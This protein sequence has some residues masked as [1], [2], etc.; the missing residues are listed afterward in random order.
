MWTRT[1]VR[2]N[3]SARLSLVTSMQR[4]WCMTIVNPGG[5]GPAV[6]ADGRDAECPPWYLRRP[7]IVH[8]VAQETRPS[9]PSAYAETAQS[10]SITQLVFVLVRRGVGDLV[11]WPV[12]G[13]GGRVV[14]WWGLG[15]WPHIQRP[16][17]PTTPRPYITPARNGGGGRRWRPGHRRNDRGRWRAGGRGMRPSRGCPLWRGAGRPRR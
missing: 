17:H 9:A 8:S 15:V 14:G 5:N 12:G 7:K 13:G 1:R 6:P 10:S 11:D 3:T 16:H 2:A 4:R